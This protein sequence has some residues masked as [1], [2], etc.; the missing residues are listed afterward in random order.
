MQPI[1]TPEIKDLVHA[2]EAQTKFSSHLNDMLRNLV[3]LLQA[4]CARPEVAA[5]YHT[6]QEQSHLWNTGLEA[7]PVDAEGYLQAFD[8]LEEEEE[9][10]KAWQKYG[11]VASKKAVAPE[12]CEAAIAR[13]HQLT[14]ALSEEACDLNKP[15]TWSKMPVDS[16]GVSLISRGFFELYHDLVMANL[17]QSLRVY[18]HHVVL[19]GRAELWTTFDRLGLKL[20]GHEESQALPL[21]VDQNPNVHATFRTIQGVLALRDC[22]VERGTYV[23]VPGSRGYFPN[24]AG[25]AKNSGEYV[26]LDT[27]SAIST[28]LTNAAQACALRQGS[29]ISWDSRTTHANSA[30]LSAIT[31]YVAYISAGLSAENNTEALEARFEALLTGNGKNVRD[32]LMHASKPPRYTNTRTMSTLRKAAYLTVLGSLLYGNTSYASLTDETAS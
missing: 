4:S 27:A 2:I 3:M 9:F 6:Y 31:R 11:I 20:P 16:E 28:K 1:F 29:L 21:H 15:E 19:W 13:M 30:N 26:E 32:A 23:G 18:L 17:R 24:Y 7:M 8:I 12:D 10:Y 14:L 5:R 25:M 22:P